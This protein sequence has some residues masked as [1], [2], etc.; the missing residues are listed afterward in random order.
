MYFL[1]LAFWKRTGI[2]L[3]LSAIA[4][5]IWTEA[6]LYSQN[7]L[8]QNEMLYPHKMK[9][10]GGQAY[11]LE[12]LID[13]SALAGNRIRSSIFLEHHQVLTR[14]EWSPSRLEATI[15]LLPDSYIDVIFNSDNEKY[16]AVRLSADAKFPSGHFLIER[17]GKFLQQETWPISP[18]VLTGL[19]NLELKKNG[20]S[21]E[22]IIEGKKVA[23][24]KG[25]FKK[26]ELGFEVTLNAEVLSAS[27]LEDGEE[28]VLPFHNRQKFT[29]I[30]KWHLA[31]I[32]GISFLSTQFLSF[33]LFFSLSGAIWLGF[34]YFY[35]SRQY[36]RWDIT[37]PGTVLPGAQQRIIDYEKYRYFLF[38]RWYELIGGKTVSK[39]EI[40]KI[41]AIP[42]SRLCD[43]AKC[44]NL[45]KS[46]TFNYPK[47]NQTGRRILYIGGSMSRGAGLRN[48]EHSYVEKIHYQLQ[49]RYPDLQSINFS[50]GAFDIKRSSPEI[51]K[52][53]STLRPDIVVIEFLIGH[54]DRYDE[55]K[56]TIR[57][58]G[59][60]GS[61]IVY[62]RPLIY[63]SYLTG[64]PL[65][66]VRQEFNKE[67]GRKDIPIPHFL[68]EKKMRE[69]KSLYAYHWVDSNKILYNHFGDGNLSWDSN[70]LTEY[71]HSL[72][73]DYLTTE[74]IEILKN[75]ERD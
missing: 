71:G 24:F 54:M 38:A 27:F 34:D 20:E 53:V 40:E 68:I 12:S 36:A 32:F 28:H 23:Q 29:E 69:E 50:R 3:F 64:I 74:L 75:R 1:K 25:T 16:E 30:F 9:F 45:R 18:S 19:L 33:P 8:F 48:L 67:M 57:A 7:T 66:K 58:L 61:Q 46:E 39:E 10:L 70:H 14:R 41:I 17:S 47:G 13:R 44:L 21:L 60:T 62:M 63:R 51:M 73:A 2:C 6:L 49:Q 15:R 35:Y 59:A 52:E 22:L 5:G 26:A 55:L 56:E 65:E 43:G 31:I 4:A 42:E 37:I 11:G 72:I